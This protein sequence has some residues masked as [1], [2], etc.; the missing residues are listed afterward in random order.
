MAQAVGLTLLTVAVHWRSLEGGFLWD[1]EILTFRNPLF[2]N[3]SPWYRIWCTTDATDYYPLTWSLLFLEWRWFGSHAMGYHAVNLGLH[4][5]GVVLAWRVLERLK[6]PGAW[7]AALVFSIHPANVATVGWV[8]Q[9]KSTL[10]LVFYACTAWCYLSYEDESASPA[11]ARRWWA[12]ALG[13]FAAALLSKS[14]GILLPVALLAFSWWR[15]RPTRGGLALLPFLALSAVMACCTV[16][17]Q[18]HRAMGV[19]EGM[20]LALPSRVALGGCVF[21]FYC[22]H[23]LIPHPLVMVYPLHMAV[24]PPYSVLVSPWGCVDMASVGAWLPSLVLVLV[25]IAIGRARAGWGRPLVPT[26]AYILCM[27]LPVLGLVEMSYQKFSVVSDHLAYMANLGL[28]VLVVGGVSRL[29]LGPR[30][31]RTV[32]MVGCALLAALSFRYEGA[33]LSAERLWRHTLA[34]HPACWV[35]HLNLGSLLEEQKRLPEAVQAYRSALANARPD[36]VIW[37][38]LGHALFNQ[39]QLAEAIHC[40]RESLKVDPGYAEAHNN[41]GTALELSGARDE[42]EK[43]YRLALAAWPDYAEA[44]N[45]LG[46]M[47]LAQ[48]KLDAAATH[49]R[50][51]LASRP[52]ENPQAL[53]TLARVRLRQGD[54]R[55]AGLL[56]MQAIQQDAGYADGYRALALVLFEGG[57]GCAGGGGAAEVPQPGS[58]PPRCIVAPGPAGRT[59]RAAQGRAAVVWDGCAGRSPGCPLRERAG[60]AP[61]HEQGRVGPQRHRGC[62]PCAPG[63]RDGGGR[64]GGVPR[65]PGC[66]RGRDGQLRGCCGVGP[67][68][69]GPGA[70]GWRRRIGSGGGGASCSLPC[71]QALSGVTEG[72]WRLR[73]PRTECH[74]KGRRCC[75]EPRDHAR[76]GAGHVAGAGCRGG[77]R[78]A[79]CCRA[80]QQGPVSHPEDGPGSG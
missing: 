46:T 40:Y 72:G 8:S 50:A 14:S 28:A 47:L 21:W 38:N 51:A 57:E 4:V 45:N 64:E 29:P 36:R 41:L 20:G 61:G 11:R 1:D 13:F 17:F 30:G 9:A 7:W 37:Y 16:W 60:V 78:E 26:G 6:V 15:G 32:G 76:I 67:G 23:F 27:L 70:T 58:P 25:A 77:L 52:K 2:F 54:A 33:F 74:G 12:L 79:G 34:H 39:G 19:E 24:S 49:L 62:A 53:A 80:P 73:P 42:A 18:H 35:A 65:Y 44:H 75:D 63:V 66:G 10:A 48:G 3:G 55:E 71:P 59:Q 56:S 43:E 5:L 31:M 22:L 68:G 69:G